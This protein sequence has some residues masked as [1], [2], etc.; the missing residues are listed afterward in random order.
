V[1]RDGL[2]TF[3]PVLVARPRV[4]EGARITSARRPLAVDGTAE[5]GGRLCVVRDAAIC[6]EVA[7][8]RLNGETGWRAA[9]TLRVQVPSS[10]ER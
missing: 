10:V 4:P 1:L 9:L 3:T 5:A 6:A 2:I 7:G 8:L